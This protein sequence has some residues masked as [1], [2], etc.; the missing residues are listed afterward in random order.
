MSYRN[1]NL[2]GKHFGHLTVIAKSK[3]RGKEGQYKWVCLCDCGRQIIVATAL[4]NNGA[5]TSCGHVRIEKSKDNLRFTQNRHLKQLNNKAPANNRSGYKNI[6]T[7][8]R[9]GKLFYRVNVV[10]DY[11]QHSYFAHSLKEA[12]EAREKLREKWWPN[13]KTKNADKFSE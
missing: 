5:V 10:Y 8:F 1:Q 3:E 12:L 6:S 2:I 7:T 13:Y 9:H 11:K 4:L